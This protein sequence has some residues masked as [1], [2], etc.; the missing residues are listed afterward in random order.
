[1]T[2]NSPVRVL[3]LRSA[4]TNCDRETAYAFERVGNSGWSLVS[5]ANEEAVVRRNGEVR[6]LYIGQQF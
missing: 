5:V 4:G 1:M 2:D 3:V 6:T